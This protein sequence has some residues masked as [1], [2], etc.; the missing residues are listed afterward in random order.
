MKRISRPLV[1]LISAA[2]VGLALFAVFQ[3]LSWGR[4][5]NALPRFNVQDSPVN[6]DAHGIASYASILKRAAPSV[7]NI[8]STRIIRD[9]PRM[10]MLDDPW[11]RRFFGPDSDERKQP[12]RHPRIHRSEGLGSGVIVSPD[13][14]ILT[15]N[16][17]V[18]GADQIQVA[19]ASGGKEFTAKVIGT[20]RPTDVAVLRVEAKDLPAITIADS[21]QLEVGD[22]VLAIGNPFGVGQTVTMGIVSALGR[23]A[24]DI[25]EYENFIQTDAAINPGNSG[26]ALVDAEGRLVGINTAIYSRSGGNEGVGFVVPV[27]LARS[28]MERLIKYGK[29]TRGSIGV[30]LQEEITPDLAA[31]F[32]LPDTAGAMVAE[33]LPNTPAARAALQSGDVIREVDGRK[34]ADMRQLRLMISQTAPGTKVTLKILRSDAAK[35]QVE[36]AVTVTLGTLPENLARGNNGVSPDEEIAPGQDSLDGVEVTDL[37]ASARRQLDIPRNLQGALVTRVDPDSTAAEAGLQEGDVLL[38]INRQAVRSADDA[39]ELCKN[40]K[41]NRVLLRIWRDGGTSFIA[42]NRNRPGR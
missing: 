35:K 13:G 22:V 24:L 16:H 1:N 25:N 39:M 29:V 4:D 34:I 32:N 11:L 31:E 14:Y 28:V 6:R 36:Q 33:V 7:V 40:A 10:P 37:D 12:E 27:N 26:G 3:F 15:A 38:E 21:D 17:V 8:Y 23:T 9:H 42:V 41:G 5:T 2:A 19:L 18:E 30:R 20:D